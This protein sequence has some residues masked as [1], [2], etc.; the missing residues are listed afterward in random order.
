MGGHTMTVGLVGFTLGAPSTP[1]ALKNCLGLKASWRT[2][3]TD[4]ALSQP[5]S[6][7]RRSFRRLLLVKTDL[8]FKFLRP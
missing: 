2:N 3:A 8:I 1:K 5:Q 4:L 6:P 7:Y